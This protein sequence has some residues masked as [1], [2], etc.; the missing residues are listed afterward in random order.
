MFDSMASY[1]C[2]QINA[3]VLLEDGSIDM[4]ENTFD[5][6]SLALSFA[7]LSDPIAFLALR[8]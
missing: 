7:T 4:H 3:S 6:F 2:S 5:W 1:S 8:L